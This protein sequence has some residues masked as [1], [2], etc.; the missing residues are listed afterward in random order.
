[1]G[2]NRMNSLDS[3]DSRVGFINDSDIYGKV[4]FRV[5]PF[6]KMGAVE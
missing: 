1:M 2:D 3:R 4:I 6:T 5:Y